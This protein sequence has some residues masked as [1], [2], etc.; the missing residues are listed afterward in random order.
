MKMYEKNIE[1]CKH[2]IIRA[3][4]MHVKHP[5]PKSLYIGNERDMCILRRK[6]VVL[7]PN[8]IWERK[9]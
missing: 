1:R 3:N 2:S 7:F 4:R 5:I 6:S 8:W 9:C